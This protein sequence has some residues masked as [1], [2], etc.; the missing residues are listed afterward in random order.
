[1]T[2]P[3]YLAL[4][5]GRRHTG[6]SFADARVNIALPLST[7]HHKDEPELLTALEKLVKDRDMS[8]I[9]IGLPVLMR[10]DEGEEAFYVRAVTEL[11]KEALPACTVSFLDERETSKMF[12]L[13]TSQDRHAQAATTI[14]AMYLER[15]K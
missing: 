15:Q 10:G 6:V 14:L 2:Q 12:Q 4:D 8:N 1:M 9:V 11:I 5:L 7:I 3:N 13:E